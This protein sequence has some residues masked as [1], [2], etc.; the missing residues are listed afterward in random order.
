MKHENIQFEPISLEEL[1]EDVLNSSS[2]FDAVMVTPPMFNEGSDDRFV[3]IY[4]AS[5]IPVGFFDSEKRHFPF[6]N[7][8]LTYKTGHSD[9]LINGSHTTIYLHNTNTNHGDAW[10]F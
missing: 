3:D 2:D 6:T 9:S 5:K 4:Q 8:E 10:Y 1:N 7:G